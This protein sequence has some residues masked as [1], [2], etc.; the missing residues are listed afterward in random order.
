MPAKPVIKDFEILEHTA[1][2]GI[3]AY[4]QDLKETFANAAKGMFS[5]ITDLNRV[6]ADLKREI[7]VE[8]TDIESLL[9]AWLNELVFL[10]DTQQFIGKKF[11]VTELDDKSLKGRIFGEKADMKRH[12]IKTGIKATTYHRLEIKHNGLYQARDYF[13]I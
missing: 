4:G 10:F 5:I 8:A 1:D 11:E 13:D 6:R 2:I 9:V 12:R 7:I 3:M